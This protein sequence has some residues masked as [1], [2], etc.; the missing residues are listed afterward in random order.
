MLSL[1]SEPSKGSHIRVKAKCLPTHLHFTPY[2]SGS[3]I[4]FVPS[5]QPHLPLSYC[6]NSVLYPTYYGC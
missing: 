1:C 4:L 5:P 2:P 6:L 3:N